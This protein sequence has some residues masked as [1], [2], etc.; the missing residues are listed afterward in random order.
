MTTITADTLSWTHAGLSAYAIVGRYTI[1]DAILA[2][3]NATKRYSVT[4]Q[5]E[6]DEIILGAF[7]TLAD[8][9]EEITFDRE[10]CGWENY[11]TWNVALWIDNDEKQYRAVMEFLSEYDDDEDDPIWLVMIRSLGLAGSRTGDG[12]LYDDPRLDL[13]ALGEMLYSMRMEA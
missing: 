10:Y 2:N 12:V 1:N 3:P 13:T 5:H 6:G 11:Q 7:E 8:A 4:I 9:I